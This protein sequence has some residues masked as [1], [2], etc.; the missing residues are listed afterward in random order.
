M[1]RPILSQPPRLRASLTLSKII[2]L[3]YIFHLSVSIYLVD[4]RRSGSQATSK[5]THQCQD[6]KLWLDVI[7]QYKVRYKTYPP[8]TAFRLETPCSLLAQTQLFHIIIQQS[9]RP[10]FEE[11]G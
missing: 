5:K 11:Y 9:Q 3:A 7:I 6:N 1:I 8:K 10:R 2:S 4:Q